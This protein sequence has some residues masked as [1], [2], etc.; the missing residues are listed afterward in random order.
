MPKGKS[1]GKE[2]H[3]AGG[4]GKG[5]GGG[6]GGAKQQRKKFRGG[7]GW[8]A[9]ETHTLN[10]Q[11]HALGLIKS[12]I[13]GDGNCLFATVA[14]QHLGNALRHP[15]VRALAIAQMRASPDYYQPFLLEE[16]LADMGVK[17]Y[18]GF[19]EK[20]AHE[21]EWGGNTE[22]QALA[23]ALSRN[24]VIHRAGERPYILSP[25]EEAAAA[26]ALGAQPFHLAYDG[27][28]YDSIHTIAGVTVGLKPEAA[29]A[30]GGGKEGSEAAGAEEPPLDPKTTVLLLSFPALRLTPEQAQAAL[31]AAKGDLDAA[32]EALAERAAEPEQAASSAAAAAQESSSIPAAAA[33]AAAA[34]VA[35]EAPVEGKEEEGEG[36]EEGVP[37]ICPAQHPGGPARGATTKKAKAMHAKAPPRNKPCPCGSAQPYKRCCALKPS[38]GARGA[39]GGSAAAASAAGGALKGPPIGS[40]DSSGLA[41]LFGGID[42]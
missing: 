23:N 34:A 11:L 31:D 13:A 5:E 22:L 41:A 36:E 19:L 24:M 14:E 42:I 40:P 27:Q 4:K 26:R 32:I 39:G 2:R 18:E 6:G 1:K 16:D 30:A 8:S 20:M 12:G 29:A 3:H 37:S 17:D 10:V 33:A 7:F 38:P 9:S 25:S 21:R 35:A 15:E 28:H